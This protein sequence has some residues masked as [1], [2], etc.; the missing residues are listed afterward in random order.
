MALAAVLA[1]IIATVAAG[2][3]PA[4]AA[5]ATVDL[6]VLIVSVGTPAVDPGLDLMDDL[7]DQLGV[8][9][10][11]L[12]SSTTDLTEDLLRSGDHGYYNGVIVTVSDT[13]L[14]GVGGAG[15]SQAEWTILHDYERE[16]GVKEAVL[17]GWPSTGGTPNYGMANMA[18][19]TGSTARW[20]PAAA[21]SIF[22]YVNQSTDMTITDFGFSATGRGLPGDPTVTAYLEDAANPGNGLVSHL[23]YPDGREVLLS[24]ISNAW[25][26]EYSQVL[27][28]G[29]LDFATSGVHLG[30]RQ[31]HLSTHV[32]DLFLS[33]ARWDPVA[34]VT[35]FDDP[36]RTTPAD[37]AATIAAQD[38][39]VST[40]ATIGDFKVDM[41]FNGLGAGGTDPAPAT[42]ATLDG[43]TYVDEARPDLNRADTVGLRVRAHP[44]SPEA[45][46]SLIG[47][48]LPTDTTNWEQATLG[49][50]VSTPGDATIDVQICPVSEPWTTGEATWNEAS[51][52]V[53]WSTGGGVAHDAN[54]C[55]VASVASGFVAIDISSV[56]DLWLSGTPNHGLVMATTGSDSLVAGSSESPYD[57]TL[58]LTYA[59]GDPLTDAV[60]TSGDAFRYINH[61]F[62]HRDM[63][64][65][66]GT[67]QTQSEEEVELN[68]QVWTELGL[69]G[70]AE[71]V[72][73]VITGKHSGLEDDNGTTIDLSDD[74]AFP[75]GMNQAMVD[76]F[77]VVGIQ[78]VA[79]D[80]SRVNTDTVQ[81]LPGSGIVMLPRYPTSVFYN[82]L[83][84]DE[85]TDEYNYIF[86]ER[87][88][89]A[90]QDPCAIPGAI[91]SPR[92]Y[93][94]ILQAEADTTVRHML[95]YNRFPHYFHIANLADYDGQGS[96]LLFDWL[97]VVMAEYETR[98][99]LPVLNLP[100]HEI[101]ER[102]RSE[103]EA[104]TADIDAVL[105]LQTG[106]VTLSSSQPVDVTVTGLAG[107]TPYGDK[108]LLDVAI[109]SSPVTVATAP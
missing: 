36:Y 30:A 89:E 91:C 100:F 46:Q 96:T 88:I 34:N 77:E 67:T 90:G 83:T 14:P 69:P 16:F 63:N 79:S 105:D 4:A 95:A 101:G 65:S 27:A 29:F 85:L 64:V 48:T 19:A 6:R 82:T 58:T 12:D 49:L 10:D 57:P 71:N 45:R 32:D 109:G 50:G 7:L 18:A 86:H 66:A 59:A 94:Q 54:A 87:F 103:L 26:L 75:A 3:T 28:Y 38:T 39:F 23:V 80:T 33:A 5:G 104:G 61:T 62:T 60:T 99:N 1:M 78:Y 8:P 17:A 92:T 72:P 20:T 22:S 9:Y 93:N 108:L 37:I 76:G 24:T 84:P 70:E 13:Y 2:T 31:V 107:G 11:V 40:F 55:V 102:S 51:A 42:E 47:F 21:G 35:T 41:A 53:A 97:N 44:S 43:D 73:V 74:I 15:L 56:V 52:G 81:Y 98:F 106:V 68:R 25:F